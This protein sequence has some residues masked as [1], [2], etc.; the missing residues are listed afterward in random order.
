[1]LGM[2]EEK[3]RAAAVTFAELGA[4]RLR[5]AATKTVEISRVSLL[6]QHNKQQN[7]SS[8]TDGRGD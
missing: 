7:R 3:M 8:S 4:L 6:P 1:M 5:P 2:Y